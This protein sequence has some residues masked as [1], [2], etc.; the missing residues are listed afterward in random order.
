MTAAEFSSS[1][2]EHPVARD[3]QGDKATAIK[4][5]E[6]RMFRLLE[7]RGTGSIVAKIVTASEARR[8]KPRCVAPWIQALY[9]RLARIYGA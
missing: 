6:D 2:A 5:R 7:A 3:Q 4:A 9:V 1:S 8:P